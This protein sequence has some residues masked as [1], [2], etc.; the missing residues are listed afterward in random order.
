MR[1]RELIELI[2]NNVEK[3]IVGKR[4]VIYDIMK[5]ILA[6]GHILIEDIPGVGKTTLVKA[7]AKSTELSCNRIQFTPDL[8]PSDITG[9]SIYNQKELAF[10]FIKGPVFSNMVLADEINRTS[11]KTQAALLEV[12]EESQVSEGNKT[13]KLDKPFIVLATENPIEH[14]GTFKLPEAQLDRFMINIDVG[15]PSKEAEIDILSL[16]RDSNPLDTL[17]SVIKLEDIIY[18]QDKLRE[19][20][21]NKSIN[22]YIVDIANSTRNSKY[23]SL[24]VSTRGVLA[25]QRIAQATALING[26]NYVIPED[27]KSNVK[28]V[29]KHRIILSPLAK[30]SGIDKDQVLIGILNGVNVPKVV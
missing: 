10:E 3:V 6:G 17:D 23:I 2:V 1:E 30:S 28:L 9:V 24:G 11:P 25:M 29:F 7:I 14:G 27:V 22:E 16:Y 15:Y 26:R 20:S 13:Y 8:M 18:L 19:I 5:G 12:M 21:I 4:A